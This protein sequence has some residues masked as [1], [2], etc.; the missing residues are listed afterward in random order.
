MK[1]I[2]LL[3]ALIA[4]T[5]A[6]WAQHPLVTNTVPRFGTTPN[7]DNTGRALTW[8]YQQ[9]T[10]PVGGT[11]NV[12]TNYYDNYVQETD[13]LTGA[14]TMQIDTNGQYVPATAYTPAYFVPYKN[15][16]VGDKVQFQFTANSSSETVTFGFGFKAQNTLVVSAN[17]TADITFIFDSFGEWREL[18]RVIE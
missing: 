10:Y 3:S 16:Y 6:T 1:K 15:V 11:L 7:A 9:F 13:V 14:L 4:L 17:Q 12:L 2:I 5:T 18:S 8:G